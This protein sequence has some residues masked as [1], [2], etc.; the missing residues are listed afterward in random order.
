MTVV[1]LFL[2]WDAGRKGRFLP[3]EL[4]HGQPMA[5]GK[6]R[7]LGGNL[8]GSVF[9]KESCW[10]SKLESEVGKWVKSLIWRRLE[11]I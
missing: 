4:Y 6:I 9:L 8:C 2:N 11:K 10:P 3:Y 1:C 7:Q 5:H